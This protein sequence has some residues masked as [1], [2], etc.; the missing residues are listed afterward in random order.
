MA[1]PH[2]AENPT[3]PR[4]SVE[5]GALLW[6]MRVW[7]AGLHRPIA[8]DD[9]IRCMLGR[10]GAADAAPGFLD[11]MTALRAGAAR[12]IAVDCVCQTTIST[13]EQALLDTIALAQESRLFEALLLLRG[14][15]NRDAAPLALDSAE[16]I[17]RALARVG[18]FLPVPE[19]GLQQFAFPVLH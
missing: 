9:R 8:A 6:C 5:Q 17:G 18:C 12:T 3:V 1:I 4:L 13:D 7:V 11:L 15:L 14:L 10:L 19:E 2:P 16:D